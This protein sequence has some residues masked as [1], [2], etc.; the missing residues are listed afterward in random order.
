MPLDSLYT[1]R[2]SSIPSKIK[3]QDYEDFVRSLRIAPPASPAQE[4]GKSSRWSL[5]KWSGKK[6]KPDL[7]RIDD[8]ELSSSPLARETQ[9][10]DKNDGLE[11]STTAA[12]STSPPQAT[13]D[14][15]NGSIE[16]KHASLASKHGSKLGTVSF[17][18]KETLQRALK[19]HEKGKVDH[20]YR[21][22]DLD[23]SC[24]FQGVTVL[25]E[26]NDGKEVEVDICA[27]H[28]LGGNAMDT[29][30]ADNGDMW[31]RDYLPSSE[32]FTKSRIMTF[33][34][35]SDL[36]DKKTVMTLENWAQT[37][38]RNLDEVRRSPEEKARPLVFICHS[39]GG[40]VARKAVS[41]I[42]A[43]S[44]RG[45]ELS[46]CGLVFLATPHSG[47]TQA[48]WNNFVVAAAGVV[49]GV[50]Q[51]VVSR[52]KA[53][54]PETVW[55]KRA[56]LNLDPRP[57]FRCFAEGRKMDI[58]G[59]GAK[60][61]VKQD[62]A[63]LDPKTPA[64]MIQN[65]DHK[66]ICKFNRKEGPY[67]TI[68][69]EL[70][71]VCLELDEKPTTD[72]EQSLR[73]FGHPRFVAHAYP[74]YKGA[75]WEGSEMD[76]IQYRLALDTP[77]V[78]RTEEMEQL[79]G[80]TDRSSEKPKL[81]VIKGIAG[82]GKTELL[83]R[84]AMSQRSHRNIFFLRARNSKS[85]EDALADVCNS[86]GFDM[87][88]NPNI[89]W[90]RW[91]RTPI[92]ER[93]QIFLSWLGKDF[94]KES[95][96]ILDDAEVFGAAS[97]QAALK[98]P[99][100]HVVMST[101]DSNL[102]G[103][104]RKC[105]DL[106]LSPLT[107]HATTLILKD[108]MKDLDQDVLSQ[109][110][111]QDIQ[112]LAQAVQ[113]HPLAAQN[114]I[115]FLLRYL[116]NVEHPTRD[117]IRILNRG[118]QGEK[119]V[120]FNFKE[121]D[122]SLW[123]AFN[124]SL[125]LLKQQEDSENAVRLL[126]LLPYLRTDDDCIDSF[127]QMTKGKPPNLSNASED[128]MVLR[129]E[130]LVVSGWLNK[131]QDVSFYITRGLIRPKSL[132]IHP[133]VLQFALLIASEDTQKRRIRELLNMFYELGRND[134]RRIIIPHAE[135]CLEICKWLGTTP[136]D[137]GLP[138]EVTLWLSN[139]HTIPIQPAGASSSSQRIENPFCS[140]GEKK[141]ND[142]VRLCEEAKECFQRLDPEHGYGQTGPVMSRCAASFKELKRLA[143]TSGYQEFENLTPLEDAV[144]SFY[145]M[146]TKT[147]IYPDLLEEM[148]QFR[149]NLGQQ[150]D[151]KGVW[152]L[153]LD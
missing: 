64:Y 5:L 25:Y 44:V 133:L 93:I 134:H 32:Y 120:F 11:P 67:M 76:E 40:L 17:T 111:G 81:T 65:T 10:S 41:E 30:T 47:A 115:P 138:S 34:Y 61:V 79:H 90:E 19:R 28:G 132:Q 12:G 125:Q 108:T 24:N 116:I 33:G 31:L 54:N 122:R 16:E 22:K 45:I 29:W 145:D 153:E 35:D 62:S 59:L 49:A 142:F 109:F 70:K 144:R 58:K 2:I 124:S 85:L 139:F 48:D 114:V 91:L 82:I 68:S 52:L 105:L 107:S 140:A 14:I 117:F 96:L 149:K 150:P 50:R 36:T 146:A 78:G 141:S 75:W 80:A 99:A 43:S 4:N 39:L 72:S 129:S 26:Y 103:G 20:G 56:F 63:A 137:L 95:L 106:P 38:L 110:S 66:T 100:W 130:Y 89:N 148:N 74:P 1:L 83:M 71:E 118:S 128:A 13:D 69:L 23:L 136:Q 97:I 123:D 27:V 131:L 143:D 46:R 15:P 147:S 55:D 126:Q 151:R 8:A 6:K 102:R 57:P 112:S 73:M 86:I 3:R 152:M 51:E 135:H 119:K 37:L 21:W 9:I 42:P 87:I 53:F 127:L 88:E 7:L 84:F 94:N 101:R 104:N 60:L 113:G 18:S 98:Y 121:K 77:L 92:A